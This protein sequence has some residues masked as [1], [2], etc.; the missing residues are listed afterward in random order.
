MTYSFVRWAVVGLLLIVSASWSEVVDTNTVSVKA[1]PPLI[2]TKDIGQLAITGRFSGIS[3]LNGRSPQTTLSKSASS[4]VYINGTKLDV[5]GHVSNGS[6][7]YK[8][9][10]MEVNNQRLVF[11][12]GS[13]SS[14]GGIES[15]N[16][17]GYDLD[18]KKA[19]AMGRGLDGVVKTLYC[20]SQR[21]MVFVG[22]KFTGPY[23]LPTDFDNP[24]SR[25]FG[26]NVIIWSTNGWVPA[27]FKGVDGEVNTIAPTSNNKIIYFGGKFSKTMDDD[28]T[29]PAGAQPVNLAAATISGGNDSEDKRYSSPANA[30]CTSN[31]KERKNP[32]LMRDLMPGFWRADFRE[33]VRPS[34]LRVLNTD[35]DGRGSKTFR[36]EAVP[37]LTPIKLS[38]VNY[39]TNETYTCD[40]SCPLFEGSDHWQEFKVVNDIT[41]QGFRLNIEGWYGQGAGLESVELY[42]RDVVSS[43]VAPINT[44]CSAIKYASSTKSTGDWEVTSVPGRSQIYLEHSMSAKK[45][46]ITTQSIT[47]YPFVAESGYYEVSLAIPGCQYS[48]DCRTRT[49]VDLSIQLASKDQDMLAS[50]SQMQLDDQLAVFYKGF[51]AATTSDFAPKIVMTLSTKPVYYKDQKTLKL[52]ASSLRL[53]KITTLTDM[54]GVLALEPQ[55][56][57]IDK[58]QIDKL[59]FYRLK[60]VLAKDAVVR[61]LL[62]LS[63]SG[64]LIGGEFYDGASGA[65]NIVRYDG[66]KLTALPGFGLDGAVTGMALVNDTAVYIGGRFGEVKAGA[67]VPNI[68]GAVK[69]SL[70]DSS[71]SPV[72]GGFDGDVDSVSVAYLKNNTHVY[73]SGSFTKVLS[74]GLLIDRDMDM[75]GLASWNPYTSSWEATPFFNGPVQ[76]LDGLS[77]ITDQTLKDLVNSGQSATPLL[78]SGPFT[79]AASSRV[80]GVIGMSDT[81]EL[82]PIISDSV[83]TAG[84]GPSVG[85]TSEA[86]VNAAL[87]FQPSNAPEG[88]DAKLIIAGH[89]HGTREGVHNIALIHDEDVTSLGNGVDGEVL[90][91]ALANSKLFIGGVPSTDGTDNDGHFH[92]FTVWDF[93]QQE[94]VDNIAALRGLDDVV[95]SG[96]LSQRYVNSVLGTNSSVV[97]KQILPIPDSNRVVVGGLFTNA[98]SLQCINVCVWNYEDNQWQ[99]LG[100]GLPGVVNSLQSVNDGKTVLAAGNF[101]VDQLVYQVALY[102]LEKGVWTPLATGENSQLPGPALSV[103]LFPEDSQNSIASQLN[104]KLTGDSSSSNNTMF[105]VSG[106]VGGSLSSYLYVW[107]G[108]TFRDVQGALNLTKSTISQIMLVPLQQGEN[109]SSEFTN[110]TLT[111]RISFPPDSKR[112]PTQA[113]SAPTV[114]LA[115]RSLDES[116]PNTR[117][118]SDEKDNDDIPSYGLL[119]SGSLHMDSYGE[120]STVLWSIPASSWWPLL[121][122]IR[123]DG[124][125][126][127]IGSIFH[128]LPNSIVQSRTFL[129]TALVVIISIAISLGLVFLIVLLGLLYVYWRN[130]RRTATA[131]NATAAATAIPPTGADDTQDF[132]KNLGKVEP[133]TANKGVNEGGFLAAG[134]LA[135][136]M[137]RDPRTRDA[138]SGAVMS[139]HGAMESKDGGEPKSNAATMNSNPHSSVSPYH[140]YL[141]STPSTGDRP[142]SS[143]G[144]MGGTVQTN[145]SQDVSDQRPISIGSILKCSMDMNDLPPGVA[146]YNLQSGGQTSNNFQ[147]ST[148]LAPA[149]VRSNQNLSDHQQASHIVSTFDDGELFNQ[150]ASARG[151]V[152]IGTLNAL[153]SDRNPPSMFSENGAFVY[154]QGRNHT[155]QDPTAATAAADALADNYVTNDRSHD[156]PIPRATPVGS[157]DV[158]DRKQE[159]HS[160]HLDSPTLPIDQ[161]ILAQPGLEDFERLPQVPDHTPSS[162]QAVRSS[163]ETAKLVNLSAEQRSTIRNSLKDHPVYYAKFPFNA[164]EHGELEFRAGERIFVIDN[165][166]DIWWMGLVDRYEDGV[167]QGVFPASYVS[168][169][170]PESSEAWRYI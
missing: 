159:A 167:I 63:S 34:L 13:F 31:R 6:R 164:R 128:M 101:T 130:K 77:M 109:G 56:D 149:P 139:D 74:D 16:I 7:I 30:V 39:H 134:A 95:G 38:Y 146:P 84:S 68:R 61:T 135:G 88:A 9:C 2:E 5:L 72:G 17:V 119:L 104:I 27:P 15:R 83:L 163:V 160:Y 162:R 148:G 42:Q 66:E 89:F 100:S 58:F 147:G 168:E 10:L 99:P 131:I 21:N 107:D 169:Q 142:P 153:N 50:V 170:P 23:R 121:Q 165:S 32:W 57:S 1:T 47:F 54:G 59:S 145:E 158:G 98:G 25:G 81:Y 137:G 114:T 105:F 69:Y 46:D 76:S 48:N 96:Q 127:A 151:P 141:G 117:G 118:S 43:L 71:F 67:L 41:I 154:Y 55:G 20:D 138:D 78:F 144:A 122:A 125:T 49:T 4:L 52:V 103:A 97:V 24:T 140:Y 106:T 40:Q 136:L 28:S 92:G 60:D 29:V 51:V 85:N 126:G 133:W 80:P 108:R 93:M 150:G 155:D 44:A 35:L 14:F 129:S 91:L 124:T 65:S 111:R 116:T 82:S 37:Q 157:V 112:N 64:L 33:T 11:V 156:P 120:L 36:M 45:L 90:V 70:T 161:Q 8:S 123:E 86:Y 3:T 22:G 19:F 152:E 26:P 18:Q 73:F 94:Y 113:G 166:D 102:D 53:N 132:Q 62:P 115:K 87:Y 110:N 12:G 143:G 75:K 79:A